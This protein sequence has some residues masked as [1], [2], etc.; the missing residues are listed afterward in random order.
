MT[1]GLADLAERFGVVA[2][3]DPQTDPTALMVLLAERLRYRGPFL[4]ADELRRLAA[5]PEP[6]RNRARTLD[7]QAR[8][9][10]ADRPLPAVFARGP[11]RWQL[12]TLA[13]SFHLEPDPRLSAAE[14]PHA[15]ANVLAVEGPARPSPL[16]QRYPAL[17]SYAQFLG[18]LPRR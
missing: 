4:T 14:V 11:L 10:A 16:A 17:A 12:D 2:V 18:P 1:E 15:L 8:R 7:D 6:D 5:E 13:W 3:G 9:F